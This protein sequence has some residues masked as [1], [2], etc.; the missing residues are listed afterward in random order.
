MNWRTKLVMV[1]WLIAAIIG[2]LLVGNRML[3]EWKGLN[4]ALPLL[5]N[6]VEAECRWL[7]PVLVGQFEFVEW[8]SDLHLRHTHFIASSGCGRTRAVA[9]HPVVR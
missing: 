2:A 7:K 1:A 3:G 9:R 8:T 5:L 4:V 6:L